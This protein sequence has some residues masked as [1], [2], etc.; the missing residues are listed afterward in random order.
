VFLER[1]GLLLMA[2]PAHAA[3]FVL[4]LADGSLAEEAFAAWLRDHCKRQ[5][6]RNTARRRGKKQ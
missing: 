3:V 2:P 6:R 4:G 5:R 1:N